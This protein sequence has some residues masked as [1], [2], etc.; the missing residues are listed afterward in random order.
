MTHRNSTP[1]PSEQWLPALGWLRNY[2]RATFSADLTAGVITAILLVPQGMAYAVLAGLP[3]EVGLYASVVPPLLYVLT[4]TSRAMSVG[5]VSVAA[6]LVAETLA[7]TGQTAGDENYLAGAI[8]LAALSGAALLLLGALR[9]GALANFLSHPVLSG[10][11]SAA[12]LIIIASQ[13]GNLTGI[14]LARGDLWRTVEG[15]ATHA[16]D[17]NG[18]TLALGVG[19]TLA[20]IGLRGPL[21]RLLSRRGMS[22]DKAQ[23]L[24]RAAP[25]LLVILTTTA[26]ATLHLDALGVATVGE[27][28]A[29]LPQPTLSFLTNPAWRELLL[30]AFM[31]AFIGYVESVSVAKVL[32]RKRRQKI[33]PNQELVALGLSNLGAAVTGTMPVA[34]GFSRSMVNFAAGAQTQFAALITAILVGTV[35][36]WLTP[37]FYYLPQAVLAAI[38]IVSVAPLIDLDTVRESWRYDRADTMSL[39]ITFGGVLVV[40]LEGGLVLGVLLSVA[41]YQ[42]RAAKPHIALVGRVPGTEHYRNIHRHRVETWPELLL[43]R[44]DESLYFANAAYLDQFVANAVAERPQLRHLVFLMN[45]V[46]HIDLSA[47]ETLI[48]LTIGLR[49]AGITVHLAEVKGPVMDRLQESHLLTELPPGRVFLSTE[50]AVQALTQA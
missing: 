35:T 33:D 29:G 4:G 13:L 47:I 44:I 12:A 16:L 43:I 26:V 1:P 40:G 42:W 38:I 46:N 48:G 19:T 39:A 17:A 14:P 34:G 5:P 31:I 49:E 11:T 28:P 2:R 7:T 9:L 41:L 37:W 24:G 20:L 22:Q 50:E 10:F 32:A 27:I 23:L 45:P 36:L 25:L 30:P 15:L 18:P 8:L 3:P 6:I 21:V